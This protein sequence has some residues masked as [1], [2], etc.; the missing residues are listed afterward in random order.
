MLDAVE[1]MIP[2]TGDG[3][4][5]RFRAGRVSLDFC[6]TLLWRHTDPVEQLVS[7]AR[8]SAWIA[9]AGLTPAKVTDA[10]LRQAVQ[11]RE[12]LYRLFTAHLARH[13]VSTADR[14][15][16]NAAAAQPSP[17][18]QLDRH[19]QLRWVA[20]DP[21]A[22]AT[23]QLA[24]DAIEVV[25]GAHAD[26][27]RECAARDCAFLFVDTSRAGQRRWCAMNRCGNREHQRDH[28]TRQL[29]DH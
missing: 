2:R 4:G 25:T 28:R 6:S 27:L 5:F 16:V 17:A 15:R 1:A 9:E 3:Q 13:A 22:A 12:S 21:F 18:P 14:G 7:P 8:L 10:Q 11:L 19:G 23:A 20:G 29:T 24:R 26:R